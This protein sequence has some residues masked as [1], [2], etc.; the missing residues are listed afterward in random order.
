MVFSYY[1]P[2]TSICKSPI[3]EKFNKKHWILIDVLAPKMKLHLAEDSP[4]QSFE[5]FG[6]FCFQ[7]HFKES[8]DSKFPFTIQKIH[9][10]AFAI[11]DKLFFDIYGTFVCYLFFISQ[12]FKIYFFTSTNKNVHFFIIFLFMCD[13]FKY[14]PQTKV[15]FASY[16]TSLIELRYDQLKLEERRLPL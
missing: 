7:Q 10:S 16:E 5:S 13:I 4:H 6:E 3:L 9:S 2:R 1:K 12:T 14:L 8:K 15:S 11:T